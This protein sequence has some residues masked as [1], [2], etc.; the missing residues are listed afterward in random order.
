M[1]IFMQIY[2]FT[3]II[4]KM[5]SRKKIGLDTEYHNEYHALNILYISA[6][7]CVSLHFQIS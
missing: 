4:R 7:Y 6:C 2:I 5:E 3:K 1:W